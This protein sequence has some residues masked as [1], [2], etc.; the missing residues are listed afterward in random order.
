VYCPLAACANAGPSGLLAETFA[1]Q[2]ARMLIDA[3]R[4]AAASTAGLPTEVLT[5]VGDLKTELVAFRGT[6]EAMGNTLIL[7]P[8]AA[9]ATALN[10]V[11]NAAGRREGGMHRIRGR[12]VRGARHC[13]RCRGGRDAGRGAAVFGLIGLPAAEAALGTC[14]WRRRARR[15]SVLRAAA[16]VAAYDAARRHRRTRERDH[17]PRQ[18]AGDAAGLGRDA[19]TVD[20]PAHG[21]RFAC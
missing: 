8:V 18:L 6:V 21:A 17:Q 2:G 20:V 1:L 16:L 3:S 9:L 5:A 15:C 10:E 7:S 14:C 11:V 4:G 13:A 19:G 12:H